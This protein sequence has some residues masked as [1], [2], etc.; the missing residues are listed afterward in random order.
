M[1]G[2]VILKLNFWFLVWCVGTLS[3][4]PFP[5]CTF[6]LHFLLP[7]ENPVLA[8]IDVSKIEN[9][10]VWARTAWSSERNEKKVSTRTA[11]FFCFSL[12]LSLSLFPMLSM[13]HADTISMHHI[14]CPPPPP[15]RHNTV[16]SLFGMSVAGEKKTISLIE[17]FWRICMQGQV[18]E[19][20]KKVSTRTAVLIFWKHV[21]HSVSELICVSGLE[22][23]NIHAQNSGLFL[24]LGNSVAWDK[25]KRFWR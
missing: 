2:Y 3:L 12:S 7:V 6:Q 14:S 9:F 15:P 19:R 17:E 4:R 24:T 18:Q 1:L 11:I 10:L 5:V 8:V 20:R 23:L 16:V 25:K 22:K 21:S 13:L